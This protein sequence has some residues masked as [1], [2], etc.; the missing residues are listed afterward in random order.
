MTTFAGGDSDTENGSYRSH[1]AK[2][3]AGESSNKTLR[4]STLR[5]NATPTRTS[6][7]MDV[8]QAMKSGQAIKMPMRGPKVAMNISAGRSWPGLPAIL[9]PQVSYGAEGGPSGALSSS[10]TTC[11]GGAKVENG[12]GEGRSTFLAH[13]LESG[14]IRRTVEVSVELSKLDS[15]QEWEGIWDGTTKRW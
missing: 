1:R 10:M 6:I 4:D 3:S 13:D 14:V 7:E 12:N 2:E 9:C 8:D 15:K 11:E 5:T